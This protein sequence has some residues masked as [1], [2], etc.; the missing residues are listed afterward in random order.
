MTVIIAGWLDVAP[1]ERDRLVEAH[2]ELVVAGRGQPG[3]LDLAISAD[4]TAPGRVRLFEHWESQ[5]T[6]DAWRAVAPQ[7][8]VPV[9][10][11]HAEVFKHEVARSG[12]PFG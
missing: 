9:E 2:R 12:P 1:Q 11:G 7:P 5:E 10:I 8:S 4:P 3:C 6:L